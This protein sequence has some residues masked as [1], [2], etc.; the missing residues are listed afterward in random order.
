MAQKLRQTPL[1]NLDPR[2]QQPGTKDGAAG[3]DGFKPVRLPALAAAVR[4][5]EAPART[6]TPADWPAILR[7]EAFLN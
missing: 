4:P 5:V 3:A 7:K 2:Y 6:P 1:Y